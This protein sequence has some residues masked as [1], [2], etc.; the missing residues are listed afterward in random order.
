MYHI[1]IYIVLLTF[2]GVAWSVMGSVADDGMPL[3]ESGRDNV[4]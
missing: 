3:T 4:F 1:F 2:N